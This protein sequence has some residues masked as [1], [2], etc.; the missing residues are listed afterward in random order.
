MASSLDNR[1]VPDGLEPHVS[2]PFR[3]LDAAPLAARPG[4]ALYAHRDAG[5]HCLGLAPHPHLYPRLD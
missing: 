4:N 2:A 3:R 1:L 5:Y